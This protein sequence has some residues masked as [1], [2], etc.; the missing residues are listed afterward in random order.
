M[1]IYF[2]LVKCSKLKE[3]GFMAIGNW[4]KKLGIF[5]IVVNWPNWDLKWSVGVIWSVFEMVELSRNVNMVLPNLDSLTM[6]HLKD[7]NGN[8]TALIGA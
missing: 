4:G 5:G 8:S 2:D 6:V 1:F 7:Q 3:L